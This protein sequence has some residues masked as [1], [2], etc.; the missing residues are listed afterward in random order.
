VNT[1]TNKNILED[2]L[3]VSTKYLSGDID[4]NR[5]STFGHLNESLALSIDD[6]VQ[7]ANYRGS[8]NII[9]LSNDEEKVRSVAKIRNI[10]V[11]KPTA[12]KLAVVLLLRKE[13]ILANGIKDGLNYTF[14]LDKRSTLLVNDITFSLQFDIVIRA[15]YSSGKYIYIANYV[16]DTDN[17]HVVIYNMTLS[18]GEVRLA[19]F[20]KMEQIKYRTEERI[21]VDMN[22]F[23][24][25]GI[26]FD[27]EKI[28]DFDIYYKSSGSQTYEL[29][30]KYY[31]RLATND[32]LGIYYNDDNQDILRVY[33]IPG[34]PLAENAEIKVEF[35]ETLGSGGKF[36][37]AG[38][39]STFQVY[40]EEYYKFSGLD[41]IAQITSDSSGGSDGDTMED[42]IDKMILKK[43]TRDIIVTDNDIKN[44]VTNRNDISVIKKRN[45]IELRLFYLYQLIRRG[46]EIVPTVT[47]N[48]KL[49]QNQFNIVHPS[50]QTKVIWDNNKFTLLSEDL[51]KLDNTIPDVSI[52]SYESDTSKLCLICPFAF[53]INSDN[54]LSY[55][56]NYIDKDI[57]FKA[58]YVN[59]KFEYQMIILDMNIKRNPYS[60]VNHDRYTVTVNG[61][62]NSDDNLG[63]VDD[64]GNI[65]NVNKIKVHAVFYEG[66]IKAGYLPLTLTS[67]N[68]N[69]KIFTFTGNFT[70]NDYVTD[71]RKLQI[72]GGIYAAGTNDILDGVID[73]VNVK[74]ELI[75]SFDT[76]PTDTAD[77]DYSILN[78]TNRT[79]S[80]KFDNDHNRYNILTECNKYMRSTVTIL[81][82]DD[83]QGGTVNYFKL[84]E[85]PFI[86]YSY[87]QK[88][89]NELYDQ[90]GSF[91]EYLDIVEKLSE[92]TINV[93]FINTY[94]KSK[95]IYVGSGNTPLNNLNPLLKFRVYGKNVDVSMIKQKIKDYFSS[96]NADNIY[97]FISNINTLIEKEFSIASI[98]Y[99]GVEL[100]DS[101][102][103]KFR[104]LKENT[105]DINYIPEYINIEDISIELIEN[106]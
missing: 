11:V 8:N 27:H 37:T 13:D 94:G 87:I 100:F 26:S 65:L 41:V 10:E 54:I 73:Y 35:K 48:M 34:S 101:S 61:I 98:E 52:P 104:N 5:V 23:T 24:Y 20:L 92:N 46:T 74:N 36:D 88:Y 56:L 68:I 71:A 76:V 33:N 67:Y 12:S 21:I 83:G 53:N 40:A 106:Y 55:Y 51:V 96:F 62:F 3:A 95:Y 30:N 86:R 66:S 103:Q 93:K 90:L 1:L 14:I 19:L 85:V 77:I 15:I 58:T 59:D 99:L 78:F 89:Y 105:T 2:I 22:Q 44:S 29:L 79:I 64:D 31:Y 49:Y 75:V 32:P 60:S 7:L 45:D 102:F 42:L 38:S 16:G 6:S 81:Q 4:K 43:Q 17:E 82:E 97:I 70:S 84:N 47:K 57:S 25:E 9:E 18:T 28:S 50:S 80:G 63:I 69:T 91:N 72:T 39:T